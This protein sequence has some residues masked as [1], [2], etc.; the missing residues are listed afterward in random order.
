MG[1]MGHMC[2]CASSF[3]SIQ[4]LEMLPSVG[5]KR[6]VF[7]VLMLAQHVSRETTHKIGVHSEVA[8]ALAEAS[9]DS[10]ATDRHAPDVGQP[11]C[12]SKAGGGEAATGAH[13]A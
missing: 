3:G 5:P 10:A 1:R 4:N 2:S 8:E 9:G 13:H 7:V 11:Y 12:A 6:I